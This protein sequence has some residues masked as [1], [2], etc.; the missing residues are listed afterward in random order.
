MNDDLEELII[1]ILLV[2]GVC[3]LG[4]VFIWRIIQ[5]TN[6]KTCRENNFKFEYCEKYKNY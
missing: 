6:Y 2:L 4:L 1:M 5:L 3:F